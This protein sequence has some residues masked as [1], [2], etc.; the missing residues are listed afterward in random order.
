MCERFPFWSDMHGQVVI[1]HL[2]CYIRSTILT[3]EIRLDDCREELQQWSAEYVRC[4]VSVPLPALLSPPVQEM[5]VDVVVRGVPLHKSRLVQLSGKILTS[6]HQTRRNVILLLRHMLV[7]DGDFDPLE[8][9][10]KSLARGPC[11]EVLR[12]FELLFQLPG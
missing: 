9:V 3:S 4:T 6:Q 7:E 1:S 12:V 11:V 10:V 2:V 8:E 5:I